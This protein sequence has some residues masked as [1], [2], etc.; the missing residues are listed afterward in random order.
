ML[1]SRRLK[2]LMPYL[3]C[4]Q[5][6]HAL[7]SHHRHSPYFGLRTEHAND[8][9]LR[10]QLCRRCVSLDETRL[11]RTKGAEAAQNGSQG[12]HDLRIDR[13]EGEWKVRESEAS[14]IGPSESIS[15][16]A[17]EA[18]LVRTPTGLIVLALCRR[19]PVD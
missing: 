13:L 1:R 5:H 14:E 2:S 10:A 9:D 15:I 12:L 3:S 19:R 17:G 8:D 6:A 4:G 7:A 16:E 11:D 18:S